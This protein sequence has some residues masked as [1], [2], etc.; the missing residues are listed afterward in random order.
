MTL[1]SYPNH[2]Y[3]GR[4]G[5]IQDF[6]RP[7]P[8]FINT[9]TVRT[10]EAIRNKYGELLTLEEVAEVFR[11]KTVAAVRKAHSRKTLPVNLYRFKGRAGYFARAEEVACSLE[12]MKLS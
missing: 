4:Y 6:Y 12:N 7:V 8:I 5:T 11:Y 9:S 3:S 1:V 2:R 10:A